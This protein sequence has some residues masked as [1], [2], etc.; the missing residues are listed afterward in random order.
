MATALIEEEF[1]DLSYEADLCGNIEQALKALQGYGIMALELIQNAD[2][3]GATTLRIDARDEA[4]AVTN[5]ESFSRCSLAKKECDWSTGDVEASD[6]R[7]TCNFHA[8]TRMGGRSKLGSE[9]Q[10]GRFGIGFVSVYQITDT[11]IVRS[12]GVEYTLNP[13]EGRARRRAIA[14]V[15]GTEFILP[16]AFGNSPIREAIHQNVVPHDVAEKL[17]DA[18]SA[19][20]PGSVL[21]L[22]HLKRIEVCRAGQLKASVDINR[23]ADGVDLLIG[24]G[25]AVQRW[26]V[27]SRDAQNVVEAQKLKERFPGLHDLK[28]STTVSVAVPVDFD[29]DEGLLYAYL[30]TK[31]AT[32]LPLHVN[33]DFFPHASRQEIVL[34]SESQESF[35]NEAMLAGAAEII[36]ERF[37]LLKTTLGHRRLWKL[38]EASRVLALKDPAFAGFWNV[39]AATAKSCESVWTFERGWDRPAVVRSASLAMSEAEQAGLASFGLKMLHPSLREYLNALS[40]A[41]VMPL[42]VADVAIALTKTGREAINADNPNLRLLWSALN[43]MLEPPRGGLLASVANPAAPLAGIPFLLDWSGEPLSPGG[44]WRL[45]D[46]IPA[47]LLET[48]APDLAVVHPDVLRHQNLLKQIDRFNLDA[49]AQLLVRMVPDE[50]AAILQ[51]GAD[52]DRLQKVYKLLTLLWEPQQPTQAQDILWNVPFLRKADGQFTTPARAL[53]PGEFRDPTGW[54]EFVDVAPFPVGMNKFAEDVLGIGVMDFPEFVSGHLADAIGRGVTL[55][56]YRVLLAEIADHRHQLDDILDVLRSVPFVRNRAGEFV[57]PS[58]CY[59]WDAAFE[60]MLG[61]APARWV[62]HAWLPTDTERQKKLR[63]FYETKLR[64][65]TRVAAEHIVDRV[66]RIAIESTPDLA[67]KEL[68]PIFRHLID[69]WPRLD[70]AYRDELAELADIAFLPGQ[71]DGRPDE[72]SL[73]SPD[74]VYRAGRAPGFSTQ[75]PVVDLAPLRENRRVVNEL[76]EL[77][78]VQEEPETSVVVDHLLACMESARDPH[79]LTYQ[80]L[81]ERCEDGDGLHE[82]DRLQDLPCI[83]DPSLGYLKASRVFWSDP[84]ISRYWQRAH[85]KMS[86]RQ[87]L[88]N[89]LGVAIAPGPANYAELALEVASAPASGPELAIHMRCMRFL[90]DALWNGSEGAFEAVDKMAGEESLLTI[91]GTPIWPSD[92]LWMDSEQHLTPFRGDLDDIVVLPPADCDVAALRKL[93]RRLGTPALSE[94]A[95][96]ELARDPGASVEQH[97][98]DVLRERASLLL[99]LAPTAEARIELRRLLDQVWVRLAPNLLT[100]AELIRNGVNHGSDAVEA[101]AFVDR[102]EPGIYLAG[103]RVKWVVLARNVFDAVA[104]LCPTHDMRSLAGT[105]MNI[106]QAS[107]LE[108]AQEIMDDLHYSERVAEEEAAGGEEASPDVDDWW[109]E[110]EEADAEDDVSSPAQADGSK[111]PIEADDGSAQ[112]DP[113]ARSAKTGRPTDGPNTTTS[114]DGAGAGGDNDDPYKS[115]ASS[116]GIGDEPNAGSGA[117]SDAK[118][119]SGSWE[120]GG[121]PAPDPATTGNNDP[122]SR[123]ERTERRKKRQSRLLSYVVSEDYESVT[124]DEEEGGD[125]DDDRTDETGIAAVTAVLTYERHHERV[126]EEMP[127]YNPGYDVIST[128]AAGNRRLIEVKGIDGEW[129][130]VGVKLSRRQFRFAQEHPE[131]FWLYV[132]EHALDPQKRLVRPLRNPFTRVDGYLFDHEWR[133]ACEAVASSK[134]MLVRVGATVEDWRWGRG[135]I[136]ELM[137]RG[138]AQQSKVRFPIHGVKAIPVS[139]LN[140]VD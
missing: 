19:I 119:G 54:F 31:K 88:F 10:I 26:V 124:R 129:N 113:F 118:E 43:G 75:V 60:A 57:L 34:G 86:E 122:K 135:V 63:D 96:L 40:V 21:F 39:F 115:K 79:P 46:N 15:S 89:R 121:G 127:H 55:E 8:I 84:P 73:Y 32:G 94:K 99:R 66:A 106:L 92:A 37:E 44:A 49:F 116:G 123:A 2:D 132:V 83:Y 134:E 117:G 16:W 100:R 70:G 42:K 4:L 47:V 114:A 53:L 133:K 24:P 93:F 30:P 74:E 85:A 103:T 77:L 71:L 27:Q 33:A 105:A 5:N 9:D 23:T 136:I 50:E 107:S 14:A 59:F 18:V 51:F 25:N 139:K 109:S 20:L 98:T 91:S 28:R 102:T 22:R 97:A 41:G 36:G 12:V 35:W 48:V 17:V 67:K 78:G 128:D 104:P 80:I 76:L 131:E 95:R 108:E 138:L 38:G 72:E 62:D 3:A 130:Q 52:V 11:P 82:I 68:T 111:S 7:R 101:D 29:V 87:T 126:P 81:G 58:A 65:P 137:G 125:E 120:R 6:G 140:I 90:A 64:M 1:P 13:R 56:Q 45:P 112:S 110:G 61:R 69:V